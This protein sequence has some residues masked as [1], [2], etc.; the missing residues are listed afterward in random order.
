MAIGV[1][2]FVPLFAGAT[3]IIEIQRSCVS[4]DASV[5][6]VLAHGLP[7]APIVPRAHLPAS[8]GVGCVLCDPQPAFGSHVGRDL[9]DECGADVDERPH[10][11]T[12]MH[13]VGERADPITIA[14]RRVLVA[15]PVQYEHGP[16][17]VCGG[18]RIVFTKWSASRVASPPPA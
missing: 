14:P 11:R 2:V 4:V 15:F 12:R 3:E 6:G 17:D 10:A 16:P 1:G 18:G 8:H 7:I 9:V 13:A 5:A